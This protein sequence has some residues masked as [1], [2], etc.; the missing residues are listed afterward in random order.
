MT[1]DRTRARFLSKVADVDAN[2]CTLW[3]GLTSRQGYGRFSIGNRDLRAHRLA[4]EWAH[5]PVPD[6]LVI[7]HL[8]RN[9]ACVNVAHLEAVTHAENVRRGSRATRTHCPQGHEYSDENT[10]VAKTGWRS[11]REC[12]RVSTRKHQRAKRARNGE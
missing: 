1:D 2:G 11:C 7:D 9:R 5:G 12:H 4:Y 8:C 10:Y 3:T 6:E